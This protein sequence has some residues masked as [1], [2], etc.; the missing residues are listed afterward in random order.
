MLQGERGLSEMV[1]QY[2]A[3]VFEKKG[4]G[5]IAEERVIYVSYSSE[6][7]RIEQLFGC[8]LI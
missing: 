8:H 5:D 6:Y 1:L 2:K 4:D 3:K 7:P